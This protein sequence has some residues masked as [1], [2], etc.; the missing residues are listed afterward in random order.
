MTE[1]IEHWG[2]T[3]RWPVFNTYRAA[4]RGFGVMANRYG[5]D[6]LLG[7]R[8]VVI[9]VGLRIGHRAIGLRWARPKVTFEE[10]GP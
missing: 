9:G 5:Q 6:H 1:R 10:V 2:R 8:G 7:Q 3:W 4:D